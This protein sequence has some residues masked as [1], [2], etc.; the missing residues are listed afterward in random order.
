[1]SMFDDVLG[2]GRTSVAESME[3]DTLEPEIAGMSLE[4]AADIDEDPMDF[5]LRVAYENEMNMMNLDAAI[6]AEEY[7]YLRENGQEMVYEEGKIKS[8]INRFKEWVQK[9]WAKIQSFFRAVFDKVESLVRSDKKFIEKYEKAAKGKKSGKIKG[10]KAYYEEHQAIV[11]NANNLISSIKTE[12]EA[13]KNLSETGKQGKKDQ[14]FTK[15][16]IGDGSTKDLLK[17]ININLAK[18]A[19]EMDNVD[20][21]KAITILKSAQDDKSLLKKTYDENKGAVNAMI[22]VAKTMEKD[23]NRNE[24]SEKA[25]AVHD[26]IAIMNKLGSTMTSVDRIAVKAVNTSRTM[27]KAVILSAIKK[28]NDSG[29]A[30]NESASLIDTFELL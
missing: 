20:T 18:A 12:V 8:V 21:S 5:M 1:M 17:A 26:N 28:S 30:K 10:V 3:V 15:L 25:S 9:L 24:N 19:V 6:V 11:P 23:F 27:A 4:E 16:K 29:K 7:M 22:K 13:L 2:F 14:I